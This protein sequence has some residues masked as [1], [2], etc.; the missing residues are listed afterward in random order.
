MFH[1][2]SVTFLGSV[3]SAEGISIDP[4][5]VR[6]VI[7]LPVPDSRDTL[8]QFLGFANFYCRF[9][10]D[11]SRVAA[12]LTSLTSSKTCFAWS[13]AA[14][15]AFD[16]LKGLFTSAPSSSLLTPRNNLLLKLMLP[17]SGWEPSYRNAH[18]LMTRYIRAPST[19]ITFCPLSATMTS[20]T[21]SFWR[22]V[23]L[24]VNGDTGSR[25]PACHSLSGRII[26]IW[27]TSAP[28]RDLTDVRLVGLFSSAVLNFRS[29]LDPALRI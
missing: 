13:G 27:R 4:D 5:K 23:W 28:L 6:A 19:P 16:R 11:F 29:R 8:Q 21:E 20:V 17:T 2:Q 3:V 18:P 24:L 9:I 15:E 7:D 10:R 14:Q 25:E 1:A 22:S 26:K 12:P